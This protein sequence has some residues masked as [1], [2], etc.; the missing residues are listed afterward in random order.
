MTVKDKII[1]SPWAKTPR[2]GI[3]CAKN[4]PFWNNVTEKLKDSFDLIQVGAGQETK[5]K[6][7]TQIFNAPLRELKTLLLDC[8]TW[9]S[10]DNFFHHFAHYYNKK[11][12]VIFGPSDPNLFGYKENVN[13]IKS[14]NNIRR[15]QFAMWDNETHD[16]KIFISPDKVVESVITL[17][18]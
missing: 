18:R 11:G 12:I 4:Y 6:Y 9:I 15:D 17:V 8:K 5:L 1:I 16:P 13:L 2:T 10:V 14:R 7:C 3:F